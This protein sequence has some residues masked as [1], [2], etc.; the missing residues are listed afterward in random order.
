MKIVEIETADLF[1]VVR[2]YEH[3]EARLVAISAT[4]EEDILFKLIY[5]IE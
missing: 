2:A 1:G 5:V 4:D 3:K